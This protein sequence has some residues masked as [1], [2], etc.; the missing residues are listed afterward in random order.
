[1]WNEITYPFPKLNSAPTEDWEYGAPTEDWEKMNGAPIEDWE[2]GAPTEDWEYI[3]NS[4]TL[5]NLGM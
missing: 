4:C 2:Y 1:M 5:E 3:S